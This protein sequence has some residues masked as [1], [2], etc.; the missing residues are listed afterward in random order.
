[1]SAGVCIPVNG[2]LLDE[3]L[4]YDM[5]NVI[6]TDNVIIRLFPTEWQLVTDAISKCLR[7]C[8]PGVKGKLLSFMRRGLLIHYWLRCHS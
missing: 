2:F 6:S 1:M 7:F 3:P 8:V 4:T 5:I